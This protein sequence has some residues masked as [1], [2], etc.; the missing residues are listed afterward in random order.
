[1]KIRHVTVDDRRAQLVL[2]VGAKP[3]L[4]IPFAKLAPRPT[5]DDRIREAYVDEELGREAVTYVLQS[6]AE[7][8][9]HVDHVLE[10]NRDPGYLAELTIYKLTFEVLRRVDRSGLTRRQLARRLGTSVARLH[11][12]LDPTDMKKELAQ[13]I[14]LLHGLGCEVEFVVSPRDRS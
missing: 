12:L 14:A 4:P 5:S 7:G 2:T 10:Y 6:G 1:V 13:L 3:S 8:T 9:V 11:R